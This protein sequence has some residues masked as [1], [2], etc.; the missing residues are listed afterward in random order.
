LARAEIVKPWPAGGAPTTDLGALATFVASKSAGLKLAPRAGHQ[1]EKDVL[2]LGESLFFRRM[3]PMD[4]A[5]ASCHGDPGRRIRLQNLPELSKPE[6][7][8]KV[9]GEW[10][11]YRVS[12]ANVMTMQNRIFDCFWQMRL[13]RID[14]GSEVT[15]ALTSYLNSKARGGE[16]SAPGLKR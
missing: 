3:G 4:F 13:P 8:R 10:P 1:K 16:I 11:A 2:A 5:C 6:E 15:V 14:M 9:I 7:A 12:T